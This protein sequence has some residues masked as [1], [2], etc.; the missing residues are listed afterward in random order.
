MSVAEERR[1]VV[2][3]DPL[4]LHAR[5]CASLAALARRHAP[6]RLVVRH[7]GQQA[8][9]TNVLDL[10]VLTV[11]GGAELELVATGP[12]AGALADAAAALLAPPGRPPGA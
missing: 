1:R 12:G 5:P 11:P 3:G 2:V 10:L 6:A 8:D 4:G 7:R 9:A